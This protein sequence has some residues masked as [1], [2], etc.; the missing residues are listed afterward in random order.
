M[1]DYTNLFF[2]N[3]YEKNDKITKIFPM[4]KEIKKLYCVI[5]K[6]EKSKM[7]KHQ[8]FLL[9]AVRVKMKKKKYLKKKN[10]LR[11]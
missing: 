3:D 8:F 1:L 7:K 2:P 6:F 4:T 9:F 5:C 10:Q 11:Y